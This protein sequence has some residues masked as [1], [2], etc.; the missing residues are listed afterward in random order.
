MADI[1]LVIKIPEDEYKRFIKAPRTATFN[2]C[3]SDRKVLVTA[4]ANGIPLPEGH[5][6]LVDMS[7]VLVKLMQYYDG[8][9]TV[10][11]CLDEVHTVIDAAR[12]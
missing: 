12:K 11:Q 8:D 1:E 10:G 9:K 2:E 3:I 5:G 6:M 4:I 7:E